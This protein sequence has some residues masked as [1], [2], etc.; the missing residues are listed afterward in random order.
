MGELASDMPISRP[1][2]SRHLRL[3]KR[4]GLV[5]EVAL[6]TRRK[7]VPP[8]LERLGMVDLEH[9]ARNNRVRAG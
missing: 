6:G 4:A 1:A 7:S 8:V 9:N 5:S 3:L 2:V